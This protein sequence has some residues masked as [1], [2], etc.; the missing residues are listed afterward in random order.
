[1]KIAI[2]IEKEGRKEGKE[3]KQD[4]KKWENSVMDCENFNL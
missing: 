1:L 4:K 3:S 2:I